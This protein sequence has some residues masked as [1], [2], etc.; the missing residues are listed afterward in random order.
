MTPVASCY[1]PTGAKRARGRPPRIETLVD[2]VW[3]ATAALMHRRAH[4]C[5]RWKCACGWAE[6][7]F[8]RGRRY[9]GEAVLALRRCET[10]MEIVQDPPR[11]PEFWGRDSTCVG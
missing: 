10:V 9:V 1:C 5:E 6:Q 8:G 3:V 7:K 2:E 11:Y 4:G